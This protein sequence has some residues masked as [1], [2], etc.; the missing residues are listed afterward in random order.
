MSR[1]AVQSTSPR[2]QAPSQGPQGANGASTCQA[3]R[4]LVAVASDFQEHSLVSGKN[5]VIG[6][7]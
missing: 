1:R 2:N 7:F 5:G 4:L 3:T 6:L